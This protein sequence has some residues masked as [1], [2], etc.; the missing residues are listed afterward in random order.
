MTDQEL[1]KI[2]E[3]V[4]LESFS[5]PFRHRARFNSRL[6]TTGGRYLLASHDIEINPRPLVVHGMEE[7]IAI[8]KH[9]LCHY[10]LHLEGKGYRHMDADFKNLL[11]QVGGTRYCKDTGARR[12]VKTRYDYKCMNCGLVYQRKRRIDTRKYACG[13]CRGRLK[14]V[15]NTRLV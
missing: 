9:E 14:L 5:K 8:I 7:L 15:G 11:R 1:Q 3:T 6:R 4:S 12:I 2:V 13:A 10:H